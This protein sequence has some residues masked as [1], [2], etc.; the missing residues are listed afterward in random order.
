MDQKGI[1]YSDWNNVVSETRNDAVFDNRNRAYGAYWIRRNYN[2]VVMLAFWIAAGSFTVAIT[3]PLIYHWIKGHGA[4]KEIEKKEV[5]A[6]LMAPP[7]VNPDE[8]PP[9]PPPPPPVVQQIKFTPPVVVDKP[10][11]DEP[12]PPVQ[13]DLTEKNIGTQNIDSGLKEAPPP[14][15]PVV[16]DKGP[17]ESHLHGFRRCLSFR[18]AIKSCWNIFKSTSIILL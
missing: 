14:E 17:Q 3:S 5:I 7:P 4:E 16:A 9:P 6:D 10:I 12:P 18:E 1:L 8:P 15:S 11:Q 2:R 13:E